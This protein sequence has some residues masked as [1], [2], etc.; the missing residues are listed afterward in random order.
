MHWYRQEPLR[1]K[2]KFGLHSQDQFS[3]TVQNRVDDD[4]DDDGDDDEDDDDDDGDDDAAH[5]ERAPQNTF[6]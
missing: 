6:L 4:D 5:M 3:R 1:A 2:L